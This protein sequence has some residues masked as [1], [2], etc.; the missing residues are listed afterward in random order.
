[1]SLVM[2]SHREMPQ[3][4][5][6]ISPLSSAPVNQF[7]LQDFFRLE[8]KRAVTRLLSGQPGLG[9]QSH[10]ASRVG[11]YLKMLILRVVTRH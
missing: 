8:G 7:S 3:T 10:Q 9:V 11:E 5:V 1:M 4:V 2:A 6:V